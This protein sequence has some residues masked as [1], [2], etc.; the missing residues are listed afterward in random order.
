MSP[1]LTGTPF[2]STEEA[3]SSEPSVDDSIAREP[4]PVELDCFHS[5]F[6]VSIS[7]TDFYF[8]FVF[9]NITHKGY[10]TPLSLIMPF[11][12]QSSPVAPQNT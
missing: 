12:C 10:L 4:N 2:F 7:E 9:T 5:I 11:H 8:F 6:K 1:S 3:L